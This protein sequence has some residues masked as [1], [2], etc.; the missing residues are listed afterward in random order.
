[1]IVLR[2]LKKAKKHYLIALH[3]LILKL[4]NH[5]LPA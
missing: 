2:W 1:M 3:V 4:P 5:T